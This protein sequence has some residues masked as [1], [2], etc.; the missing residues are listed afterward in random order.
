MR[1]EDGAILLPSAFI[2]TA[3]IFNLIGNI[4]RVITE[5]AM[6]FQEEMARNGK[7]V[8]VSMNLSGKNL[9]DEELLL[10]LNSK[11]KEIG[12]DPRYLTFEITETAA[13]HN[14]AK[15]VNFIK[16]LKSLG[17]HFSLDDFGVGFTSFVYL[18]EMGVD[19]IKI[20]G[21]FIKNLHQ[22]RN[23][24]LFV[25]A[26]AD[27]AQG[28]GIKTIAEFVENKETIKLLKGYGIDYAQGYAIG[29]PAPW[30]E[31]ERNNQ[32]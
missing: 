1:Q 23:D 2:E 28:M 7:H 32:L 9:G 5:K 20:D 29:K 14:M 3:E 17:C 18:R 30:E 21:S 31:I 6:R 19:Y 8:S 15:A 16:S 26:I 12:L 4:D 11:I 25:K 24:Q 10:F 22:S 13:V 27:V